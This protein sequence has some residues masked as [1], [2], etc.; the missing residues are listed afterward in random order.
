MNQSL[1][2][3]QIDLSPIKKYQDRQN[4]N[5]SSSPKR[6]GE[7]GQG[8]RASLLPVSQDPSS[9]SQTVAKFSD[10]PGQKPSTSGSLAVDSALDLLQKKRVDSPL[11]PAPAQNKVTPK[12]GAGA[13]QQ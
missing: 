2:F 12:L 3:S 7:P 10:S 4:F 1:K 11:K 6:I 5:D 9:S 8:Q 13:G